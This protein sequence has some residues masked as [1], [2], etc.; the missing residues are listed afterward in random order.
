[1]VEV[2]CVPAREQAEPPAA[3][4]CVCGDG[5]SFEVVHVYAR[6]PLGETRFELNGQGAYRR[7]LRRCVRC[8]HFVLVGTTIPGESYR[9]RYVQQT[10]GDG[11]DDAG[12]PAIRRAFERIRSLRPSESDNVG[13]VERVD[14]FARRW[15]GRDDE[16]RNLLDVGSGLGVFIAGMLQ[17]GWT[18]TGVDPDAHAC[19]HLRSFIGADAYCA[20][21][22]EL[23]GAGRFD[24]VTLN[25]VLEHVADPI[26]MLSLT[27]S[28]LAP[29]GLV[30]VEV[31][32]G[33]AA[34]ADS[35][36]REEFFIEHL[37]AFSMASLGVTMQQAGLRPMECARMREPS[38]KYTL[39]AFA[40]V[41]SDECCSC[42]EEREGA[43]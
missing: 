40:C 35:P 13:R 24:V 31:P 1:V 22:E 10:Y 3:G 21:F 4:V 7:E 5:A 12:V 20:T 18:C 28:L 27:L 9:G 41:A 2:K 29:H 36:E 6:P 17:H 15:C 19:E 8:G 30:Y 43:D 37:H 26:A 39:F 33:E 14:A 34:F 42:C 25:K 23:T 16:R 32:D 11:A 38:G